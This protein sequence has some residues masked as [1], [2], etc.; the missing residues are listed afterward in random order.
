MGRMPVPAAVREAQ[1]DPRHRSTAERERAK[2]APR[3]TAGMPHMPCFLDAAAKRVWRRLGPQL[4]TLGT[5]SEVDGDAFAALCQAISDYS[6]LTRY[7]R[8]NGETNETESGYLQPRPE[9]AMRN[10]AFAQMA[11]L[12]PEFGIGAAS[13]T[14]IT[15]EKGKEAENPLAA[16]LEMTARKPR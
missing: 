2:R 11:K 5:L 8:A 7:L 16:V 13:R 12:M 3:P 14:R 9:V 6:R 1:G 15:V 10:Q 4:V